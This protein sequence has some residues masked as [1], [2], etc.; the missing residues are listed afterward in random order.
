MRWDEANPDDPSPASGPRR[1]WRGRSARYTDVAPV[2][3]NT[4]LTWDDQESSPH[5]SFDTN[6]RRTE[7]WFENARSLQAKLQLAHDMG[8]A[9]I[10]AW[11]LGQEDPAFWDSLDAWQIRHPRD[12]LSTGP[13]ADRSRRA[14]RK[15]AK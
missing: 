1:K 14:A 7:L 5:L 13:L 8:F 12:F 4:P 9:G 2:L 3:A 6:G 10:S 15:I 11:V